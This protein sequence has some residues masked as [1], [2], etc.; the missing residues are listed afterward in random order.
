MEVKRFKEMEIHHSELLK[1]EETIWRQRSRAVWLGDGD[2]NTKFFHGKASQRRKVNK[3][4]KLKDDQGIWWRGDENVERILTNYFSDLFTTSWPT[5][6]NDTSAVVGDKLHADLRNW[7]G[8]SYTSEDVQHAINDMHPLKAPGPDGLPALFFQK[9][10]SNVGGDVTTLAL[11]ILNNN[12]SPEEIN[13]T[14]IVLIPKGK[15][16]SSPKDFRPISLCNVVMKV[17]KKVVANR[18]KV[19]HP[20]IIDEEQSA[21]IQ[22]RL[23]T[24]NALITMECFHLMKKKTKGKRGTRALKLSMSKAYDRIEWSFVQCDTSDH[25]MHFN[26]LIPNSNKWST[27]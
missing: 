9:Y 6:L 15:N 24:N 18:M 13:K 25:E 23:I 2:R 14:F 17:V 16:P 4:T 19:V 5:K 8:M 21:F 3:T 10:W 20:E 11:G 12:K 7:C 27:Y 1:R 22:G 26:C